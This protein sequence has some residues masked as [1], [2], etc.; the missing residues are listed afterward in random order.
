MGFVSYGVTLLLAAA[1]GRRRWR[2]QQW[3]PITLAGKAA[4]D[5]TQAAKLTVGQWTKHR[6]FCF[7]CL[8]AAAAT[9]VTL[10]LTW[11]EARAALSANAA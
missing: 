4:I 2:E 5:A 8:T 6:A 7:W 3:L 9:F 10:P 11:R 1:G